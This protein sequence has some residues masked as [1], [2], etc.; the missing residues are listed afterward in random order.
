MRG[1]MLMICCSLAM[2]AI[3]QESVPEL[4]SASDAGRR[5][6]VPAQLPVRGPA[7]M[8]DTAQVY[9]LVEQMPVFPKG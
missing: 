8:N 2:A 5:K 4:K 3:A 9:L 1:K 6:L 7:M